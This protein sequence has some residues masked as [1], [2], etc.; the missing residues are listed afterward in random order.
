M[1]INEVAKLTGVTVRTLHYYD[2]IDLLKPSKVSEASYRLYDDHTIELLQQILFFKELDFP[3]N[4]I[5][6]IVK[7]ASFDR[8]EALKKHKELLIKK[9]KRIDRLIKLV[10]KTIKGE[11]NMSFKEFDNIDFE[12]AKKKYEREVKERWG[13]TDAYAESEAKTKN[14]GKEQWQQVNEEGGKILKAFAENMEKSADSKEVQALVKEW[15][16]YITKRFY[17][18]TNEILKGLGLMYLQDERFKKNIDSY[19][20]GTAEFISQAIAI[21]CTK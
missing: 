5:K 2:E 6:E 19:G 13:T 18:C 10:E 14:Y 11:C 21:Y 20:K 3:L 9:R 16:D 8:A 12:N 4:E 17:K 1:K 7:N 15:Q